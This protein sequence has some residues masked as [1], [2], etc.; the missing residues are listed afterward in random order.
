[1][2]AAASDPTKRQKGDTAVEFAL[3]LAR[4]EFKVRP[5]FRLGAAGWRAAGEEN[6]VGVVW[7]SRRCIVRGVLAKTHPFVSHSFLSNERA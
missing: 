2:R 5:T 1:M 4:A 6:E 3:S 7:R